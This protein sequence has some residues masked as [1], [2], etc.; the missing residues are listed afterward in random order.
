MLVKT[1]NWGIVGCGDVVEKKSGPS[2]KGGGRS[3]IVAV[4]RR[5]LRQLTAFADACGAKLRTSDPAEVMHFP[6]VDIVYVA[7]PP[8]AHRDYV[9]AAAEAGRHVLV[10]KPMGM[11]A[12]DSQL[13]VDACA[14]N[15]VELFVA[16]YRRFQPHV[17]KMRELVQ[18]GALGELIHGQVEYAMPRRPGHNWGWRTDPAVSGGGL[19]ADVVS[20]RIDL[21]ASFLGEPATSQAVRRTVHADSPTEDLASVTTRFRGGG[22]AT[23]LGNF[24]SNKF[25][26]RFVLTGTE[27]EIRTEHLDGHQFQL[28]RDGKIENFASEPYPA[29]HVGLV[30]HIEKVLDGGAANACSGVSGR[31]TDQVLEV[32]RQEPKM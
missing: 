27:G 26:D 28:V 20:H 24:A 10:E 5:D 22:L 23:F 13:M 30:R 18:S 17:L 14:K 25:I 21:M 19:F 8:N 2:I 31:W 6:D 4:M 32:L 29:P 9:I 3:H 16:Y 11:N 1:L 12:A 7:T 15:G